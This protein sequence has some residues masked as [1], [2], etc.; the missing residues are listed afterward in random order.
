M[1]LKEDFGEIYY[2][3]LIY[4]RIEKIKEKYKSVNMK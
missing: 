1:F 2:R 4:L 3:G